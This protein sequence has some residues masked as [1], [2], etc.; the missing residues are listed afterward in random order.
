MRTKKRCQIDWLALAI[1]HLGGIAG[2]AKT[3]RVKPRAVRCWLGKGIG[4]LTFARVVKIAELGDI[5]DVP[6]RMLARAARRAPA[7]GPR[8]S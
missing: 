1:A 4:G 8:R 6:F 5:A 7:R 2:A 3:M